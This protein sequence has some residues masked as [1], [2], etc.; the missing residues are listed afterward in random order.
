MKRVFTAL[1]LF[2]A[3][4][5][6]YA[7]KKRLD[8]LIAKIE[9]TDDPRQVNA[10]ADQFNRI[11]DLFALLKKGKADLARF[12]NSAQF[13]KEERALLM[14]SRASFG[15]H[16]SPLLLGTT[17]QGLQVSRGAR[18][19]IYLG[20]F[21][22]WAGLS[23][24]Y[25][26]DFRKSA[27]YFTMAGQTHLAGKDTADAVLDFSNLETS[28]VELKKLDSARIVAQ[29]EIL[30]ANR[31]PGPERWHRLYLSLADFGEVLTNMGRLDSALSYYHQA[32][33]M[34]L[35]HVQSPDVSYFE[36]NMAKTFMQTAQPDSAIKYELDAYRRSTATK[37]W[38]F[39]ANSAAT[40]SKL[41]EGRDDKK[42]LFYLKVQVA[43][44][45]SVRVN[46]NSRQFQLIADRDQQRE[47]DLKNAAAA[48]QAKI[49]FYGVIVI[50]AA[51]GI[52]VVLLLIAYRRQQ[53]ANKLLQSQKK[54]TEDA[55][56][57]L[58]STQQQLIQS[59]KMASL[60]ELTAG[61]AHE[62]QNPLNFV[63]NF[64]EVNKE[65]LTELKQ[66]LAAKNYEEVGAIAD[67]VIGNEEKINHHGKRA[68]AIVK[69]MLQH[70]QSGAGTKEPT[71]INALADECMRLSYHGFRGKDKSFNTE[72]VTHFD[73]DLPKLDVAQQ[74]IGRVM[75][76]LFNNA[77]Y[78]VNQKLKTV[79]PDYKPEVS[80]T[81]SAENSHVII[82]VKDNGIGIP[83]HIKEKIMQPFFTTKPTGEGTGLG[84]SLSYDIVV[85]GHGGKIELNTE[86]GEFT[87]F[88]VSLPLT[89]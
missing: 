71:N 61:I 3:I 77:F 12:E 17:L 81:T 66:E 13:R 7:Q 63:N 86:E 39:T 89:L 45:D 88:V 35:R 68:D 19:T 33:E 38:E 52:I 14:I 20:Y 24:T 26:L 5:A 87:E 16:D 73:P 34:A 82:T 6:V 50:L 2:L 51:V 25:E 69:G 42:S 28:Y 9:N 30:L 22:H 65:L 80:I 29:R 49:R 57:R 48:Y 44:N 76:N 23:Y 11:D 54:Q 74:D 21:L 55:L 62:I 58:Q 79:G 18:D 31:L 78:A 60:G 37:I 1:I 40:L 59:E 15:L 36:T 27:N 41:Y 32:Y 10:I 64:S 67:G 84:L 56:Q 72:T 53:T 4:N 47:Q 46:E 75:L 83:E 8:S 70:S 43:A 85:K